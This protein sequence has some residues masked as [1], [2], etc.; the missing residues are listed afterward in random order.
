MSLI[1]K[2]DV[3]VL[4]RAGFAEED[5]GLVEGGQQGV[6]IYQTPN[7]YFAKELIENACEQGLCNLMDEILPPDD[8][9][10]E[11]YDTSRPGLYDNQ[12]YAGNDDYLEDVE[13]N[14]REQVNFVRSIKLGK[15]NIWQRRSKNGDFEWPVKNLK[16]EIPEHEKERYSGMCREWQRDFW[17]SCARDEWK[18]LW[19]ICAISLWCHEIEDKITFITKKKTEMNLL[20]IAANAIR[21]MGY[22]NL[23]AEARWVT[24]VYFPKDEEF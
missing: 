2:K 24:M 7:D 20:I 18:E 9:K 19:R 8:I 5:L 1:A 21:N 6:E 10:Q 17:A 23:P 4:L 11:R 14:L 12:E 13:Q 16:I 15:I 22:R 3:D